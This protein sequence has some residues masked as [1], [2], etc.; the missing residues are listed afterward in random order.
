M[1]EKEQNKLLK[2]SYRCVHASANGNRKKKE[3]YSQKRRGYEHHS[4][5]IGLFKLQEFS[6]T[7]HSTFMIS[8][9]PQHSARFI[10]QG[11][12]IVIPQSMA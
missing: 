7:S 5:I 6:Y 4:F 1:T 12:G 3:K 10:S 8:S 11:T 9:P 2:V